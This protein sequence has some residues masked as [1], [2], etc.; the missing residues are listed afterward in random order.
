MTSYRSQVC[1]NIETFKYSSLTISRKL[2]VKLNHNWQEKNNHAFSVRLRV[3]SC[4][5]L[6]LKTHLWCKLDRIIWKTNVTGNWFAQ[7]LEICYSLIE[8]GFRLTPKG[9]RFCS[10]QEQEFIPPKPSDRLWQSLS[11]LMN[12]YRSTFTRKEA[13]VRNE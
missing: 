11:P 10:K 5:F 9:S 1:I 2:D 12:G 8:T 6:N 7:K 4:K 3:D 13:A